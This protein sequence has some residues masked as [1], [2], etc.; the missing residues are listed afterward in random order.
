MAY[1]YNYIDKPEKTNEKVKYILDNFSKNSPDGLIGNE[2]CGQMSAWYVMS[3]L[4][5]YAVCPGGS[6]YAIGSPIFSTATIRLENQKQFTVKTNGSGA[7]IQSA[8]LNGKPYNKSYLEY[9]DINN[10]GLIEFTMGNEPNKNWGSGN[11]EVPTTSI[12]Q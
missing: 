1:L 9:S 7:Y 12:G 6:Q 11:S 4:G 8:Q 2:D 10:G 3:A 5:F